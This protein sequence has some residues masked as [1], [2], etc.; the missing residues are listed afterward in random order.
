MNGG[1]A[2]STFAQ[3]LLFTRMASD[4]DLNRAHNIESVYS[5]SGRLDINALA[6]AIDHVIARHEALRTVFA[7]EP[8]GVDLRVLPPAGGALTF[9][10]HTASGVPTRAEVDAAIRTEAEHLFDL[11]RE[12][13][14][15][16]T[17]YKIGFDEYIL[18]VVVHHLVV[19]GWSMGILL[20]DLT[21]AYASLRTGSVDFDDRRPMQMS[22]F[23]WHQRRLASSSEAD[24][25][26]KYWTVQ[27]TGLQADGATIPYDR[28]PRTGRTFL[29]E[30][31]DFDLPTE[32]A[33]NLEELA[34]EERVTIAAVALLGFQLLLRDYAGQEDIVVGVPFANRTLPDVED[35]VGFLVN[36]HCVRAKFR[37]GIPL[38]DLLHRTARTLTEALRHQ[39]VPPIL[40]H[41]DL[42]ARSGAENLPLRFYRTMFICHTHRL[43]PLALTGTICERRPF[44]QQA[45]K[46][47]ITLN[48]WP[49]TSGI[50]S[51]FEYNT[52][53]YTENTIRQAATRYRAILSRIV[54]DLVW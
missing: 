4:P 45:S 54:D 3:E 30:R 10:D 26:I 50:H 21:R 39:E 36:V 5:V 14:S 2:P 51:Q 37:S 40:V 34:R 8:H 52:Q 18:V 25:L 47:D 13:P 38:R 20:R 41:R 42:V 22:E 27:L 44:S 7:T 17:L 48:V 32:L 11:G 49:E 35:C 24:P 43:D 9:Q 46:T 29:G 33:R 31:F 19:D 12:L 23:S 28:P 15:R 1:P 16:F 6:H 53:L